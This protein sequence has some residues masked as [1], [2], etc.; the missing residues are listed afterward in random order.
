VLIVVGLGNPGSEYQGTRHNIGFAVIDALAETLNVDLAAGRGEYL[1]GTGRYRQAGVVLVK[2]LTYMNNSGWA[3]KEIVDSFHATLADLMI[4]CDDFQLPLGTLRLRLKGS[5]GGHNGLYSIIYQLQS[6][7]FSRLRCGIAGPSLP[8]EKRR[9][10]DFVLSAFSHDEQ[11]VVRGMIFRARDAA[12][13][14][15]DIGIERAMNTV[16]AIE[17]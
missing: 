8:N 14:A 15:S 10:A 16:N 7:E 6:E 3:V 2:P 11:E 12:L 13:E 5:D 4:V 1:L 9:R 17:M